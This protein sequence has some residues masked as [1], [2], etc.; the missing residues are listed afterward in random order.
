MAT[1]DSCVWRCFVGNKRK[2]KGG[3][4]LI[5]ELNIEGH[6]MLIHASWVDREND[7]IE[8][9]W[10]NQQPFSEILEFVGNMPLPPYITRPSSDLDKQRYQTVYS[11]VEGAV[12]APTA[13]LHFTD[14]HVDQ[15]GAS[16]FSIKFAT[17]HVSAGT[18]LPI[19][20][21]NALD[22]PIHTETIS[23]DRGLLEALSKIP[24]VIAVGTTS[25]RTLESVFWFGIKLMTKPN[26]R[27][28]IS[29]VEPYHNRNE[30][31]P[32]ARDSIQRVLQYMDDNNLTVL[33]GDSEIFILPGY[34]FKIC[35][36][37]ITNF[38]LPGSTLLL[39][40]A[41]YVGEDWT[42]I[43]QEALENDYRFLSYGD[44]SLLLPIGQ[45]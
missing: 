22:H 37:M 5:K 24:V 29:K 45:G 26:A 2:W 35:N 23:L 41:A 19:K 27:F 12:A 15:L 25:M 18:F 28:L 34:E 1:A 40:V 31:L 6:K 39:L 32:P 44:S 42:R 33:T 20:T 13:G 4:T 17:L 3:Q 7:F 36:G 8:F 9:N 43:Y 38:H 21:S 10:E 30:P 11:Q 14:G 16:G